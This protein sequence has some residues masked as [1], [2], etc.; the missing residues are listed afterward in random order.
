MKEQIAIVIPCFNVGNHINDVH[1]KIPKFI[2]YII[3]IN[4]CSIDDT[5]NKLLH[6][7][8][9]DNRLLIINHKKNLGVGGA[10]KSGFVK[11]IELNCDIIFKIDGDDQMDLSYIP[12]MINKLKD[13]DFVKGNRFADLSVIKKMP[14]IRRFGNFILS[15][16]IKVSSGYW[17]IF[18]PTNGYF[19]ITKDLLKKINLNN[20]NN[21]YFFES[22]LIIELYYHSAIIN[23]IAMPP[24]YG[25][26]KSNLSITKTLFTFPFYLL[27]YFLKRIL[28]RYYLYD[29]NIGSIYIFFGSIL[30][31]FGS[32]FG[33]YNWFYYS[34]LKIGAPTGTI[35]I[36]MLTIV[37]G[38]QLILSAIQYDMIY[39]K[40]KKS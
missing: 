18:D 23:E 14:V 17:D 12:M 8:S 4:D 38:F 22:S 39:G 24:I 27:K 6:L 2:D 29:F 7:R 37:L 32:I 1:K 19:G 20:L 26:E 16:L 40:F 31:L 15:F 34:S 21:R 9:I 33:V 3:C 35:I 25:N 30:F 28:Y 11:A 13:S 36:S 5:L 10:V